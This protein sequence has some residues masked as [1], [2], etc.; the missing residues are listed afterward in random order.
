MQIDSE[1]GNGPGSGGSLRNTWSS[2]QK[3]PSNSIILF[4]AVS[5]GQ[6]DGTGPEGVS[7]TAVSTFTHSR[8]RQTRTLPLLKLC[9][10]EGKWK[11]ERRLPGGEVLFS[12]RS[13][14]RRGFFS[15]T[16]GF[17]LPTNTGEQTN[18]H[19]RTNQRQGDDGRGGSECR[20]EEKPIVRLGKQSR[21]QL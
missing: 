6:D 10:Q 18:C 3:T 13:I 5:W 12:G 2:N 1:R 14:R 20:A 9:N 19:P 11:K 15:G 16:K 17:G 4:G 8:P 7:P 21:R